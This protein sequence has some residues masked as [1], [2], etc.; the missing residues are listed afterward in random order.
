LVQSIKTDGIINPITVSIKNGTDKYEITAGRRRF[1]ACKMLG[2]KEIPVRIKKLETNTAEENKSEKH[3]IALMEN[4]H[5][6]DLS[7]IEKA[8]GILSVY[9]N[10]G[11]RPDMHR[12]NEINQD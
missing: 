2:F 5:R 12:Y 9:T 8:E 4:L 3:R 11:Y 10:A 1:K 6:K 7:D